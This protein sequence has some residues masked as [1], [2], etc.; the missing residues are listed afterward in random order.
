LGGT[1]QPAGLGIPFSPSSSSQPDWAAPYDLVPMDPMAQGGAST[2]EFGSTPAAT[3]P[4]A[5]AANFSQGHQVNPVAAQPPA[6]QPPANPT[7]DTARSAV[8]QAIAA[9]PFDPAFGPPVQSLNAQPLGQE[10]IH[11]APQPAAPAG[12]PAPAIPQLEHSDTPMLVLPSDNS[13]SMSATQPIAT[14]PNQSVS[15]V[16]PPAPPAVPPPL[17]Q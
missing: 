5:S 1:A 12:P 8:E 14:Q 15:G 3:N 16:A 11:P 13:N 7:V 17:P 9:T 4:E 10:P 2:S 6:P